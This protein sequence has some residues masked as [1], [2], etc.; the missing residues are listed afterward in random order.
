MGTN[1]QN[2]GNSPLILRGPFGMFRV[3]NLENDMKTRI[4]ID[5][6]RPG[7]Q[8]IDDCK[9]IYAKEKYTNLI[10]RTNGMF[11]THLVDQCITQWSSDGYID[12]EP[13]RYATHWFAITNY[14]QFPCCD[15]GGG[16]WFAGWCECHRCDENTQHALTLTGIA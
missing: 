8:T 14:E 6:F 15:C 1:T 9:A 5:E 7:I 11:P 10:Y 12:V 13:D 4:Y 16:I 3:N 2:Q